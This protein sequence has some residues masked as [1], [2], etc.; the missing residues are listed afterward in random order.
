M[1]ESESVCVIF[2]KNI[3]MLISAMGCIHR[4]LYLCWGAHILYFSIYKHYCTLL[5]IDS[6]YWAGNPTE[7]IYVN[8]YRV[9]NAMERACN[10]WESVMQFTWHIE[11]RCC[12]LRIYRC[13]SVKQFGMLINKEDDNCVMS[14]IGNIVCYLYV[15]VSVFYL[16]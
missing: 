5:I 16:I 9:Y 14:N 13:Y 3:T 6:Q 10:L 12:L 7:R 1:A 2:C 8:I 15:G 4:T 11:R